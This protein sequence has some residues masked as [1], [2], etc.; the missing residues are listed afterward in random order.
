MTASTLK[1]KALWWSGPEW[2]SRGLE[3][4]PAQMEFHITPES[5]Q[6]EKVTVAVVT[7]ETSRGISKVLDVDR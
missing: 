5:R 6:E 1:G 3:Q 4:W 7:L 2:F